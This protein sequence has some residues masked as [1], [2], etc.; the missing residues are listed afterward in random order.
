MPRKDG[1]GE[2]GGGGLRPATTD[3]DTTIPVAEK[4][5]PDPAA[6]AA[7]KVKQDEEAQKQKKAK[8]E[9]ESAAAKFH[10]LVAMLALGLVMVYLPYPMAARG[11]APPIHEKSLFVLALAYAGFVFKTAITFLATA[12]FRYEKHAFDMC[13]MVFGGAIAC[14]SLQVFSD[15]DVFPGLLKI[16]EVAG[17]T[18]QMPSANRNLAVL[19]GLT[20]GSLLATIF[21]CVGVQTAELGKPSPTWNLISAVFA[22]IFVGAYALALIAKA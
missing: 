4:T 18:A 1:E 9:A 21:A 20:L 12:K 2:D 6:E 8:E 5:T 16:P 15:A 7:R 11:W 3:P 13:I 17:A 22:H 14:L 19:G 10:L